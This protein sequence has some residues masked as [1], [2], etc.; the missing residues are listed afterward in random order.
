IFQLFT[1]ILNMYHNSTI[2]H[3]FI[4]PDTLVNIVHGKYLFAMSQKQFQDLKFCISQYNDLSILLYGLS[5]QIQPQILIMNN[6]W[7]FFSLSHLWNGCRAVIL[8]SSKMRPYSQKK[9]HIREGL[10]QI[11]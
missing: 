1:Q 11:I 8:C 4:L 2:S 6:P 10:D 5:V 7:P 9:F 3:C